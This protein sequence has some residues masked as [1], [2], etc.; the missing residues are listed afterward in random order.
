[1]NVAF[2][3]PSQLERHK[4]TIEDVL[5]MTARGLVDKRAELLD[6]EIFDAPEDG[7]RHIS[8]AMPLAQHIMVALQGKEYFVGVQTTLRLSKHNGPS[9]DIYVLRGRLPKGDVPPEQ[10]LLVIEVAD[11][12][13]KDDLTDS[14][15]RYARHGV[16]DY[17][18]VDANTREIHLHRDPKNGAYPPPRIFKASETVSAL[19]I[20]ELSTTLA[21]LPGLDQP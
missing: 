17:W 15:S 7:Y 2:P 3:T 1:M 20:P 10:I 14:A 13:L 8:V 5:E 12:S 18:V 21:A 9:P 4:F 11:T 16:H 6:G 19:S